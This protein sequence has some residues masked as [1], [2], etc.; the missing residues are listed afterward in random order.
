MSIVLYCYEQ[1]MKCSSEVDQTT[2]KVEDLQKI[3]SLG[4]LKVS[5]FKYL[6]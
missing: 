5:E 2:V 6:S 3:Y 1:L 4:Q